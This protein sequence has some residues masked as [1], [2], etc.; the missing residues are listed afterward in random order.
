[1]R[2]LKLLHEKGSDLNAANAA[3]QTPLMLCLKEG[4]TSCAK[5]LI[6]YGVDV[7]KGAFSG[8]SPLYYA[9]FGQGPGPHSIMPNN[10]CLKLLILV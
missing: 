4:H 8:R 3:G 10:E 1:M 9:M 7:H 6:E 2:C 5:Q